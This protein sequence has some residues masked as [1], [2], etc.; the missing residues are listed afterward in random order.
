M[1]ISTGIYQGGKGNMDMGGGLLAELV[2]SPSLSLETGIKYMHRS[3]QLEKEAALENPALP[4][5]DTTLGALNKA[6]IETYL[7]ELPM[8]LKFRY[9]LTSKMH[10]IISGGYTSILYLSQQ[11]EY[12]YTYDVNH[13]QDEIN[14]T[15][16]SSERNNDA[17]F[18]AGTLN[19]YT[20]VSQWIKNSNTLELGL[21]YQH[22][23]GGLGKENIQPQFLGVRGLYWF[24]VH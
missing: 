4:S 16:N 1:D 12:S 21:Y 10:W 2:L 20:G 24:K 8:N 18:Y 19:F 22:S 5:I 23:L 11:F 6:E 7:L 3:Y 15:I 13:G 17:H 14:F 9:P